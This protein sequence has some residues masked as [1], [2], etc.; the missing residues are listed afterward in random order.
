MRGRG[1]ISQDCKGMEVF[2]DL[3]SHGEFGGGVCGVGGWVT[4]VKDQRA[5]VISGEESGHGHFG[6]RPE[7]LCGSTT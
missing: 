7:N 5:A 4:G 6:S 2:R 3:G 1:A